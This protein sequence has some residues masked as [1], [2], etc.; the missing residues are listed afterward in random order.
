MPSHELLMI[1]DKVEA[2]IPLLMKKMGMP[3]VT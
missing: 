3:S 2:P 1:L